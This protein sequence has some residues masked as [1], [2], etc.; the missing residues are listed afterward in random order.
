VSFPDHAHAFAIHYKMEARRSD[1]PTDDPR[2]IEMSFTMM[3]G[4]SGPTPLAVTLRSVGPDRKQ[5]GPTQERRFYSCPTG[6]IHYSTWAAGE[7]PCHH[8]PLMP[9]VKCGCTDS[10]TYS[11][12]GECARFDREP[13]PLKDCRKTKGEPVPP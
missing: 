6:D 3:P 10:G 1:A 7:S 12:P 2:E 5:G 4:P 8:V 13:T 11:D 9:L